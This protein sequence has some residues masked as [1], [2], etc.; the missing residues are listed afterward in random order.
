MNYL[1]TLTY[2]AIVSIGINVGQFFIY[3]TL[4][5]EIQALEANINRSL[6]LVDLLKSHNI[7]VPH[8]EG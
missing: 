7:P 8:Q 2:I 4:A 1:E 3:R 5:K 6:L